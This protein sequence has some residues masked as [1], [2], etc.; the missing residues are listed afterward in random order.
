MVDFLYT[1]KPL[2]N[3]QSFFGKYKNQ[4]PKNKKKIIILFT[5][6]RILKRKLKT[7][8]SMLTEERNVHM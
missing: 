3:I 4:W 6:Q 8:G 1:N 5:K 7:S 2:I